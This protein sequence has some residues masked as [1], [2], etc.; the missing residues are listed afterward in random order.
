MNDYILTGKLTDREVS[1]LTRD[2]KTYTG[3][4][5]QGQVTGGGLNYN[6]EKRECMIYFVP[7]AEFPATVNILHSTVIE[8]YQ[9]IYRDIDYS[10]LSSIQYVKYDKGGFFKLHHDVIRSEHKLRCLTMS[11]NLSEPSEYDGGELVVYHDGCETVL[12]KEIGSYIIF[13]AFLAH[14][15]KEVTRGTRHA[16]VTWTV[17]EPHIQKQFERHYNSINSKKQ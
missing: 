8:N 7:A 17:D 4:S 2:I 13:P 11:I 3:R 12:D 16:I 14:E 9:S 1:S 15:C 6:P 5:Y 10:H